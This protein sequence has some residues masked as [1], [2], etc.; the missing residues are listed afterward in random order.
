MENKK[1]CFTATKA[2]HRYSWKFWRD[3]VLGLWFLQDYTGYT[4]T[5][6]SRWADSVL[7]IRVILE[8]HGMTAEVS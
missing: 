2:G 6:E 3:P 1:K 4:R 8:N 5:L 7:R